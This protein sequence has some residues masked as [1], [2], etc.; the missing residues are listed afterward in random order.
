[1]VKENSHDSEHLPK[2]HVLD[3]PQSISSSFAQAFNNEIVN[4]YNPA[5]QFTQSRYDYNA[6]VHQATSILYTLLVK[7]AY[8][9]NNTDCE[10]AQKIL[11]VT[12]NFM[13]GESIYPIILKNAPSWINVNTSTP[14]NPATL[15]NDVS[16]RNNFYDELFTLGF[17]GISGFKPYVQIGMQENNAGRGPVVTHVISMPGRQNIQTNEGHGGLA[18]HTEISS[19]PNPPHAQFL[20]IIRDGM[21]SGRMVAPVLTSLIPVEIIYND[22][23]QSHIK[24]L[25]NPWFSYVSGKAITPDK[26]LTGIY[27]VLTYDQKNRPVFRFHGDPERVRVI[28]GLNYTDKRSAESALKTLRALTQAKNNPK[29]LKY[30]FALRSGYL[31]AMNNGNTF[32]GREYWEDV[33]DLAAN[34]DPYALELLDTH[35]NTRSVKNALKKYKKQDKGDSNHQNPKARWGMRVRSYAIG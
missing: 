26:K 6:S 14:Q 2:V 19:S 32:H 34:N 5:L 4:P 25:E 27:P 8:D 21:D 3:W 30:A 1:M 28:D 35:M 9:Q 33:F 18:K 22:L 23:S 31:A 16:G 10:K 17:S 11:Q 29:I 24:T 12:Q 7:T 20:K 15:F 13:T